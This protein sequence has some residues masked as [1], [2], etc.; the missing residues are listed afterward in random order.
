VSWRKTLFYNRINN[1]HLHSV[2]SKASH[3]LRGIL[4]EPGRPTFSEVIARGAPFFSGMLSIVAIGV[5]GGLLG[6][7]SVGICAAVILALSPW[8]MRYSVEARGYS[9]MLLAILVALICAIQ[10]VPSGRLR[11]WFGYAL[12]QAIFLLAFP[13]AVYVALTANL[14]LAATIVAGAMRGAVGEKWF[15][16]SRLLAANVVSAMVFCVTMVMPMRQLL[17]TIKQ[18]ITKGY[19]MEF[20]WY[21]DTWCHLAAG[22]PWECASQ[23]LHNGMSVQTGW[24]ASPAY[25]WIVLL[26]LPGLCLAGAIQMLLHDWRSR[27]VTLALPL[28]VVLACAHN[29][30]HGT[31]MFGWYLIYALIPFALALAWIAG[32]SGPRLRMALLAPVAVCSLYAMVVYEPAYRVVHFQRQP[33]REVVRFVRGVA[34]A[35]APDDGNII[36]ATFGTSA[37]QVLSYD[38]RVRILEDKAGLDAAVEAART[39]G[40]DLYVYFCGS[41]IPAARAPE[42]FHALTASGRFAEVGTIKGLEEMFTY[43]VYKLVRR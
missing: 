11:W 7:R 16:L 5:L 20:G 38:P 25:A 28:A 35:T 41:Q 21:R 34:Q 27:F 36:T 6:G 23:G 1:H 37:R 30:L 29:S 13:G 39:T 3:Q 15:A 33:M 26:V 8:H 14:V 10:A 32:R 24:N 22:I 42:L 12:A 4:A 43:H 40:K 2:A 9:T 19:T 17:A 18:T 31:R